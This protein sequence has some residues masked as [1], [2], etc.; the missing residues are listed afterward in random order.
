MPLSEAE[1]VLERPNDMGCGVQTSLL[2]A[3]GA[4]A[5]ADL[6]V[7]GPKSTYMISRRAALS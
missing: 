5:A 4:P 3:G 6:Q 1:F 2:Y 7:L